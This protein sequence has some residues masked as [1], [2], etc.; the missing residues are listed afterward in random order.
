M[1]Q[2]T[3][4]L[5]E[6]KT[7]E[8]VRLRHVLKIKYDRSIMSN[9]DALERKREMPAGFFSQAEHSI[10]DTSEVDVAYLSSTP[11]CVSGE[12]FLTGG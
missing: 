1:W 10:D 3:I 12:K 6:R 5:E 8:I 4:S 11:G 9:N 2:R 7:H